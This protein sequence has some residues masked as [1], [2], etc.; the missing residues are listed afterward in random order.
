MRLILLMTMAVCAWAQE[1]KFY[2]LDFTVKE[3]E[4]ARVLSAKKY[5]AFSS[6]DEKWSGAT[7]RSGTKVPYT[8]GTSPA[9]TH[10]NYVDVGVNIDVQMIREVSGQLLV[11]LVS[12]IST[13]PASDAPITSNP[14]IRQNRWSSMATVE[15]G[16]P[17]TLF[18]SDDLNS[19]RKL[20][21]ELVAT[22]V[23]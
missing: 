14:I 11:R 5:T 13:I 21:L 4:E 9:A 8:T 10:F 17:I 19:K 6:T 1:A 15:P 12:E 20:Q 7:I 22:L 23:K 18:S 2:R 3:L 16:K